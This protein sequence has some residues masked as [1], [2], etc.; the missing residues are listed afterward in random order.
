MITYGG[1]SSIN[2]AITIPLESI[3]PGQAGRTL[4]IQQV[5]N[6]II[7]TQLGIAATNESLARDQFGRRR[8]RRRESMMPTG[9]DNTSG[10]SSTNFPTLMFP[11]CRLYLKSAINFESGCPL[12]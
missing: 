7:I 6:R 4:A 8:C 12:S 1:V 5:L 2:A 9:A 3:S 11:R 10:K